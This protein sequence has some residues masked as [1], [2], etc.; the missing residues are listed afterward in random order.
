MAGTFIVRCYLP[1]HEQDAN[2]TN[3]LVSAIAV[4]YAIFI[5]FIIFFSMNNL[6]KAEL[7]AK[8]EALLASTIAYDASFL[9]KLYSE[10]IQQLMKN[11]LQT[12]ID[13]EW[14]AIEEGKDNTKAA[15]FLY[16]LKN[17]LK[18]YKP[19]NDTEASIWINLIQQTNQLHEEHQTRLH[20]AHNNSLRSL[21]WYCFAVVTL[22]LLV[23]ILF[24]HFSKL[25]TQLIL[26]ACV[27]IATGLVLF[28]EININF[29]YG[30]YYAV[31]PEAF[32]IALASLNTW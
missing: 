11:Y 31:K 21:I 20:F 15:T 14:P 28:T 25:S 22:V 7:S 6:D 2:I 4:I 1:P 9:P 17:L 32:K 29:P 16:Q 10:K 23:A 26:L 19:A 5:G 12:V 8:Q 13:E 27:A 3:G 24:Y 18:T 30:G